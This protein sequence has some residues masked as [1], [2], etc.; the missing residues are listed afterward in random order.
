MNGYPKKVYLNGKILDHKDAKISVFDR[1]FIFGDG[2][3]EVMTQVN[4]DFFYADAHLERLSDCLQKVNID[5]DV[6]SLLN[7]IK[8]LR[9]VSDLEFKDCL[10]Y[11][12]VTRGIAPRKHAYPKEVTPT[13][14]M[15][16]M[17]FELPEI[18]Q[19]HIKAVTTLDYRWGR[20]DIKMT[21]LLGNVMV[22][23]YAM[24]HGAYEAILIREGIITEASHC[25]VFFTKNNI[26]YTHPSNNFILDGITRQIVIQLC[27]DLGIEIRQEAVKE[28][29]IFLMDEVFLTGTTT[30]I[31]SVQQINEY[32]FYKGNNTGPITKKLQEAFLALKK[33]K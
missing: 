9:K 3:Y 14:M 31:V 28:Q 24:K 6:N 30:Q 13:V 17:P 21:S 22:N 33:Q 5:F 26:V 1:G 32:S 16:I 4:G 18:N 8:R 27:H 15:Y 25:N 11:I 19:K 29:D 23:E 20:C 12:Q 2:I 10:V 7:D